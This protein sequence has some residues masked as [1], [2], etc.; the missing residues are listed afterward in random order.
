M[1]LSRNRSSLLDQAGSLAELVDIGEGRPLEIIPT[2]V[3]TDERASKADAEP[4]VSV[5][6]G[7]TPTMNA[8]FTA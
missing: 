2:G 6:F 5:N 4:G 8:A 7:I 1:P 3:V